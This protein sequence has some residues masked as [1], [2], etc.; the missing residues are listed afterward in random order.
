MPQLL[1]NIISNPLY[2]AI[3][4]VIVLALLFS[5]M[6]RIIKLIVFVIILLLAFLAYVHYTGGNVKDTLNKVKERVN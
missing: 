6:K 1:D 3:A 4:V 2:L 5:I